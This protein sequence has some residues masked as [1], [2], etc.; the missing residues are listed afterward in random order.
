MTSRAG[1]YHDPPEPPELCYCC[2]DYCWSRRF[3]VHWQG[4]PLAQIPMPVFFCPDCWVPWKE[5]NSLVGYPV[6]A[7]YQV[8]LRGGWKEI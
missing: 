3:Q 1:F 7:A 8:K 4:V 6:T 2:G 5:K